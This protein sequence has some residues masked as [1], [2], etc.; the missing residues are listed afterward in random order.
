MRKTLNIN[1]RIIGDGYSAFV[2]A[3]IGVNHNGKLK[4]AM[5]LIKAAKEAGA[6]AVK[7][8]KRDLKSLYK[9]DVLKDPNKDSQS[10]AYLFDIFKFRLN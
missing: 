8:Q 9:Q 10:T 3:E 1:G 6:D 7:F 5:R 4:L 2:A